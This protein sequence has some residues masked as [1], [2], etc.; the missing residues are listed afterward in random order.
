MSGAVLALVLVLTSVGMLTTMRTMV[1][2]QFDEVQRQDATVTVTAQAASSHTADRLGALDGVTAVEPSMQAPVTVAAADAVG[3]D[4]HGDSYGTSLT[5][6]R[7]D[8]DMHG[9][10]GR[11]G[12]PR[13]LPAEGVLA[14]SAL[15]DRL[16]V[17]AGN[18]LTITTAGGKAHRV[19]LAGFVEEPMGTSL[20]GSLDTVRA[21][22]GA[23]A[24]SLLLRFTDDADRDRLRTQ[25]S[26]LGGVVAYTD[27]QALRAQ[28]DGYL[29]LFWIFTGMMLILGGILAFAVIYVTMTV[30]IAERTG[31]LATLRAS[32][33]PLRRVAGALA[34]ENLTATVLAVPVGLAVGTV[35]A[36]AF[37]RSFS[38]DLFTMRLDLGWPTLLLAAVGV[39][40]AAAVSQLPAVRAVRR[41]D[42]ARV[43]RERAQ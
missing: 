34:A 5:G 17:T 30:N 35:V 4:A 12:R 11:D 24:D 31:E 20:Y 16:H 32:G 2:T 1:R 39:V 13:G 43:V 23:P 27:S 7:P 41:L 36:W 38:S 37:M 18:R 8:T 10:P 9:F 14:G 15:A 3:G 22:T 42:I 29:G 26:G 33:V 6:Y 28:V 40:G 19:A 25:I 21:A